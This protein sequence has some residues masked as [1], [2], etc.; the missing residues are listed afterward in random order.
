LKRHVCSKDM[1]RNMATGKIATPFSYTAVRKMSLALPLRSHAVLLRSACIGTAEGQAP[2]PQ[3]GA[4]S[5]PRQ[6]YPVHSLSI[7]TQTNLKLLIGHNR[8]QATQ[9]LKTLGRV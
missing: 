1:R 4:F 2:D 8:Q 5:L 9:T 7:T 6:C 3:N